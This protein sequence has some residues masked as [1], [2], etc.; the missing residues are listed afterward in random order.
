MTIGAYRITRA[1]GERVPII[2]ENRNLRIDV[3]RAPATA[4]TFTGSYGANAY[5]G[6]SFGFLAGGGPAPPYDNRKLIQK[7][8]FASDA[9]AADTGGDLA[10]WNSSSAASSSPTHGY[11]AG[12][13][14][15]PSSSGSTN[16]RIEK[17]PFAIS[18]GT[19]ALVGNTSINTYV[20]KGASSD[21]HGYQAGGLQPTS[22]QKTTDIDKYSH[23][24]D[25][26]ATKIGDL[27]DTAPGEARYGYVPNSSRNVGVAFFS[28][29]FNNPPASG[30]LTTRIQRFPFATDEDA[31]DTGGD[32]IGGSYGLQ[33]GAGTS[34]PTHAYVAGGSPPYN[35]DITMIQKFPFSIS[36]GT[37]S[38]VG[39][40]FLGTG[41]LR[42][43]SSTTH[44]YGVGGN[45]PPTVPPPYPYAGINTIQKWSISSDA[46]GTD[47]SDLVQV[48]NNTSD[49]GSQV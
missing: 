46:N 41:R 5:Q 44:G 42:G 35:T 20:P 34:S 30:G 33:D 49:P 21:T 2:D 15:G 9:N 17:Y 13:Y 4:G 19:A 47:V 7:F 31:V 43:I 28:G 1:N 26:D 8:P 25:E 14:W 27:A 3:I 48:S 29:G 38:D 23:S 36:S 45:A 37:A 32:L 40:L 6:S 22:P 10:Q 39:D 24:S 12:G 16:G 18:S 11:I